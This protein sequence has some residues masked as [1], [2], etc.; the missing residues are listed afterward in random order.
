MFLFFQPYAETAGL[1]L[2]R[3]HRRYPGTRMPD[4]SVHCMAH[5]VLPRH[6]IGVF[7]GATGRA[8]HT[9]RD[10][11]PTPDG[12][13]RHC[14]A[15]YEPGGAQVP[16]AGG[17]HAGH[18][19]RVVLHVLAPVSGAHPVDHLGAP[20]LQHHADYWRREL[21][22]AAV[23]LPH[24]AVHQLGTQSHP[25]QP[26]VV[27]VPGR[28]PSAVRSAAQPVD[29]PAPRPQGHGDDNLSACW[30]HHHRHSHHHVQSQGRDG[31]RWRA[32]GHGQ[33]VRSDEKEW[34]KRVG[35]IEPVIWWHHQTIEPD[36]GRRDGSTEAAATVPR[37]LRLRRRVCS[38]S[39]NKDRDLA[40]DRLT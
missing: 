25:V 1:P 8:V 20:G 2:G 40:P 30:W 10:H 21:L 39:K 28:I 23:L 33:R 34:H 13:P 14:G 35:Q 4:R 38:D 15:Q 36:H 11:C 17:A 24:N 16:P 37:E 5:D 29:R 12:Q 31:Q 6:H 27:Q 22:P 7:R 26:D 9:V 3:V 19:G 32:N 18:R